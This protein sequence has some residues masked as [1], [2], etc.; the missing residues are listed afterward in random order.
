M[1]A[2]SLWVIRLDSSAPLSRSREG[3]HLTPRVGAHELGAG[4]NAS[5]RRDQQAGGWRE[6]GGD[7]E[8][9]L[10][11][12]LLHKLRRPAIHRAALHVV[13][14]QTAA[15]RSLATRSSWVPRRALRGGAHAPVLLK[16]PA[17]C[18]SA[19][20]SQPGELAPA[21]FCRPVPHPRRMSRA[22]IVFN[23]LCR[24]IATC[25]G[26]MRPGD[27]R[28]IRPQFSLW[29]QRPEALSGQRACGRRYG[30]A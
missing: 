18:R 9:P 1:L 2:G 14:A 12:Q 11:G 27:S 3:E 19:L 24:W 7:R 21:Q 6:A 22:E 26:R 16:L 15:R 4:D 23:H 29:L 5:G 10:R 8:L 28:G 17:F 25:G 20:P 30:G 13:P